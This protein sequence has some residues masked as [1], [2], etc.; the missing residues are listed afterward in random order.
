MFVRRYW[1]FLV[2]LIQSQIVFGQLTLSG[3]IIDGKNGEPLPYVS[4]VVKATSKG[5]VSNTDGFFTLQNIPSDT[6]TIQMSYLGYGVQ[7]YQLTPEKFQ[8]IT[9]FQLTKQAIDLKTFEVT[10]KSNQT[11]ELSSQTSR[12]SINPAQLQNLP[13]LGEVDVFRGLQLLP[14]VSGTSE[15][16][17]GLYVRGGT[18]DQ[19]LV[20][21]DGINIYHVDHFFGIFSPF[22]AFAIKDVQFY[23]GGFPAEFGGRLSSVVDLTAK[24]GNAKKPSVGI[25]GNL[26]SVNGVIESPLPKKMGSVLI[27]ARRSYTDVL[28]SPTYKTLFQNVAEQDQDD[29]G[30]G[31]GGINQVDP[32]FFFYDVNAKITLTPTDKDVFSLS[33]FSSRDNLDN[34]SIQNFGDFGKLETVDKTNWGNDGYSLKWSRQFTPKFYSKAIA[35][36]SKYNSDYT[37]GNN[38]YSTDSAGVDT[39]LFSF[40]TSQ[41]NTV[42]DVTFRWDSEYKY[43]SNHTLKL[44]TWITYNEI[45]YLNVLDDTLTLQNRFE[46]GATNAFYVQNQSVFNKLTTEVGLRASYFTPTQKMYYEP[47]FNFTYNVF[48]N[49]SVKGAWG[50]YR[51]FINRVIL[52][53]VFGGSRDFWLLSD[54]KTLPVSVSQHYILGAAFED[55]TWLV[56]VEAYRKN[57]GGLLEYSLRFGGFDATNDNFDNLFFRGTGVVNG[58]DFLV[59]RKMGAFTGWVGYT[60]SKVDYTFSKI[61]QGRSFPALHDQRHE[62]KLIASYKLG[63]FDFASTFIYATGKPFTAPVGQYFITML[64]GTQ[65]QYVHFGDKNSQRLPN[66]HR[67]DFSITYNYKLNFAEGNAGI[68]FFNVYN[69]RNIKYKRFFLREFDPETFMPIPPELVETDIVLLGFVPNL[70]LS[71]KF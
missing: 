6:A 16:S 14:G 70:F 5:S 25:N 71:I 43:R 21:L 3:K 27:A 55:K 4:I 37:L 41:K 46:T 52:E 36:Y 32:K 19:N 9:T 47:R 35:S 33:F 42:E 17:S 48:G 23:K 28:E 69:R 38:F 44:G 7:S 61:N 63:K 11:I 12:V 22:N 24:T 50:I 30:F 59:Q 62:A 31:L 64:D 10:D 58:L 68:S 54:G 2:I 39:L 49:F 51:Q 20:L 18:P 57:L 29:L 13:N 34:S 65:R 53:N 56:D 45:D 26:L 8:G 1:L 15:S 40:N 67:L 60:L 66:Y